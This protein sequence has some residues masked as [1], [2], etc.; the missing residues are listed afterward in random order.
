VK[1]KLQATKQHT[2]LQ[3]LTVSGYKFEKVTQ[4]I[5][6]GTLVTSEK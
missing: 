4:L 5:Y 3:H 1:V 2:D 6:I